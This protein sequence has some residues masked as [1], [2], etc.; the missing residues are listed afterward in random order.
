LNNWREQLT[1][2]PIAPSKHN[3][4]DSVTIAPIAASKHNRRDP[5]NHRADC[6]VEA[7]PA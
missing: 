1:I 7:Q 2:A 5:V 3:R 4:R 6:A